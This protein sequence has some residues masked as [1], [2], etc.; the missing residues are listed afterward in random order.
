VAR[1]AL[2][3]GGQALRVLLAL[4]ALVGILLL[5][6]AILDRRA[7][8]LDLTPEQRYTLSEHAKRV[9]GELQGDVRILAF[10]R[11]QDARNPM[12]RDLLRQ[13]RAY[14]P[15]VRIDEVDVNR[16]PALAREHG[17]DSYGALVVESDGRRRVFS[18][19]REE[20][21]IAAV[22]QVTRQQRHTVGWVT[23]HGEGDLASNDRTTGYALGRAFLEQQYYEVVPVSLLADEVPVGIDV[24]LVAGPKKDFL[25][26]ELAAFD[27]YLQRPGNALVLLDPGR[28]PGLAKLLGE[29]YGLAMPEDVVIDPGARLYGGEYVTMQVRVD[30]RTHPIAAGVE[31]P[32]LFSLTRSIRLPP[33]GTPGVAA[34]TIVSTGK[35]SWATPDTAAVRGGDMPFVAGRDQRGPLVVG[36]ESTFVAAPDPQGSARQGRLV[37][38]G[39][40]EFAN[41]FFIEFLG[42]KDLFVNS[43]AW[44]AHDPQ[45][46][47]SRPSRQVPGMNQFYVSAD[48]GTRIFWLVAVVQPAVF[49]LVGIVLVLRRRFGR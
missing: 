28:A 47:A 7:W 26:E 27:R 23:G 42:N 17:V 32:P 12:I 41:N 37:V 13:V 14:A 46:I 29:R 39:N 45:A 1:P 9:L 6:Q 33:D 38:Y 43:V 2:T 8:R 35:D 5:G 21:L 11:S 34:T 40:A 30:R 4:P 44:L 48:E 36:A 25:P 22:L 19:P 16:S 24:L 15:R 18:N 31:A 10:L 20:I 3:A 49:A